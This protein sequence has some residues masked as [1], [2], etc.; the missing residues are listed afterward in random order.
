MTTPDPTSA[1]DLSKLVAT[2][3][4]MTP[5]CDIAFVTDF[6]AYHL[7]SNPP[8]EPEGPWKPGSEHVRWPSVARLIVERFGD[9]E[10]Y[11]KAEENASV[12]GYNDL[13]RASLRECLKCCE[14]MTIEA[15]ALLHELTHKVYDVEFAVGYQGEDMEHM[16]KQ[17]I[18][19]FRRVIALFD[20]AVALH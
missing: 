15:S 6:L 11:A 7:A 5:T 2:L 9:F 18:R 17:N 20:Q 14:Q 8:A 3:D 12:I 10:I 4:V 19:H 1:P 13:I 16:L